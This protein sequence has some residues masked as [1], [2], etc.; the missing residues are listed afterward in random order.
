ML[1]MLMLVMLMFVAL[2]LVM[3]MLVRL[4]LVMLML[5]KLMLVMLM[6]VKLMLV[7]LMLVKLMLV[8]LMLVKLM[9]VALMLVMLMLVML[10]L[11]K[12]VPNQPYL[13]TPHFFDIYILKGISPVSGLIFLNFSFFYFSYIT[14]S[15]IALDK[16]DHLI[17]YLTVLSVYTSF[18]GWFAI[19]VF[20]SLL[21]IQEKN[22]LNN[23]K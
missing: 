23:K 22:E 7:K 15:Y 8:M 19:P 12:T 1:V 14:N 17:Q 10:M 6:L 3:L 11:V 13:N 4:M 16:K 18:I 21:L 9:F 20:F 2:M 5:V